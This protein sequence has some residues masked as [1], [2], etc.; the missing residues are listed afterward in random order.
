MEGPN[1][2][3]MW[4]YFSLKKT[5]DAPVAIVSGYILVPEM[6]GVPEKLED[7]HFKG[8]EG[9]KVDDF[10]F[11]SAEDLE[12]NKKGE[13]TLETPAG[14]IKTV[15]YSRTNNGQ[16]FDFWMSAEAEPITLVKAV[17][18]GTLAE[19]NYTLVLSSLLKNVK[20]M[21]DPAKAVPFGPKGKAILEKA[22][23]EKK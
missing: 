6:N 21:I 20:A 15:H 4:Q 23:A 5:G 22:P 14:K 8:M 3:K 18:A 19:Q 2:V 1:Q 17:S 12:K 16:T 10:L 11:T 13:E 7:R 9:V